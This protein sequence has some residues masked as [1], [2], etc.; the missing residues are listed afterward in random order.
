MKNTFTSANIVQGERNAK[1]Q[2]VKVEKK[3]AFSLLKEAEIQY[4]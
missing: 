4:Y 3:L 2:R 1:S